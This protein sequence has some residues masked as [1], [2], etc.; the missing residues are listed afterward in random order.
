MI[1]FWFVKLE[2]TTTSPVLIKHKED[3]HGPK[4]S[5]LKKRKAC[6]ICKKQFNKE[7]NLEDHMKRHHKTL[8]DRHPIILKENE[9]QS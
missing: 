9:V 2:E 7:S 3:H 4:E 6:N 1:F 8:E 5:K